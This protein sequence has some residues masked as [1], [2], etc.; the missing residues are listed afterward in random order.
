MPAPSAS[1]IWSMRSTSQQIFDH[2]PGCLPNA[3]DG[4]GDAAGRD[5]VVVLD[6]RSVIQ[7]EAVIG[8][9]AHPDR[10]FLEHAQARQRLAGVDDP[11]LVAGRGLPT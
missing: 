7:R 4:G 8:P 1:S 6:H 10:V 3:Q 5:D 11:R 2:M 9:A